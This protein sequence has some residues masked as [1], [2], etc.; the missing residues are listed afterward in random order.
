[1]Q[2]PTNAI[3]CGL[4]SPADVRNAGVD[5]G[6]HHRLGEPGDRGIRHGFTAQQRIG[7]ELE[8]GADVAGHPAKLVQAAAV[9]A[10]ASA[11]RETAGPVETGSPRKAL[12]DGKG[13][14]ALS[15]LG[16]STVDERREPLIAATP[17][18]QR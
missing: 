4:P 16:K 15:N 5:G 13:R 8:A 14:P 1:V 2:I 9:D 17:R 10:A 18:V 12:E 7:R 3:P 6:R 11:E